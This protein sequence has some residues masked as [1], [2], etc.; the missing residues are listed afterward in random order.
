VS[1]DCDRCDVTVSSQLTHYL[2]ALDIDT[3]S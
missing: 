3:E 1:V 2:V